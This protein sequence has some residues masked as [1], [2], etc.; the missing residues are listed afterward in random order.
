MYNVLSK[1]TII[2]THNGYMVEWGDEDGQHDGYVS[3]P[4]GDNT[5]G[6]YTQAVIVLTQHLLRETL[7]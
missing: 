7:I 5:F 3:A 4:N 1:Y 6:S 2:E